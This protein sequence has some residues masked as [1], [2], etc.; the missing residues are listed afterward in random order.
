VDGV[1]V[2]TQKEGVQSVS[3]YYQGFSDKVIVPVSAGVHK[4]DLYN[5]ANNSGTITFIGTERTLSAREL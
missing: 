4:V 1:V 3:N 2:G 5:K